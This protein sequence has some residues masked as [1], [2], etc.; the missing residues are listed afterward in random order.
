MSYRHTSRS[1]PDVLSLAC[2][3]NILHNIVSSYNV[4][5]ILSLRTLK[6]TDYTNYLKKKNFLF[7]FINILIDLK[8][9]RLFGT[10]HHKS[11][12]LGFDCYLMS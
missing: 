2:D 4:A 9:H 11:R 10:E 5:V 1:C 3:V 12:D 6:S 7:K 8:L